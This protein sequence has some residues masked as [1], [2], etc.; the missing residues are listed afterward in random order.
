MP[1]LSTQSLAKL[2]KLL[3]CQQATNN[4]LQELVLQMSE[5]MKS[6]ERNTPRRRR[7]KMEIKR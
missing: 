3:E 5:K 1:E 4:A 7:A 2:L 6:T